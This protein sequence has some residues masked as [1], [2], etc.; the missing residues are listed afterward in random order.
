MEFQYQLVP[1][2][3]AALA[4]H[5][6]AP[7]GGAARRLRTTRFVLPVL[8]VLLVL[9]SLAVRHALTRVDWIFL[10]VGAGW[11]LLLPTWQSGQIARRMR[12][13][14]HSGLSRDSI[15]YRELV[16]DERGVTER[17]AYGTLH[18]HWSGI[19]RIA[20]T[21]D[22]LFVYYAVHAALIVPKS[23]LGESVGALR[24][25]LASGLTPA[26]VT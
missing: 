20:E 11:I 1:D 9:P 13:L 26:T 3:H 12:S 18:R 17:T 21:P 6:F 23:W 25:A 15:G 2:D 24:H 8:L 4:S 19:E 5:M 16:V 22:H 14:A 7:G 10:A